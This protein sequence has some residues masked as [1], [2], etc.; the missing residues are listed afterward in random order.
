MG[1]EDIHVLE[2]IHH[3]GSGAY[4]TILC[5][6]CAGALFKNLH[7]NGRLTMEI[8]CHTCETKLNDSFAVFASHDHM[9]GRPPYTPK[10]LQDFVT[11][12]WDRHLGER[13]SPETFAHNYKHAAKELGWDWTPEYEKDSLLCPE[14]GSRSHY[15]EIDADESLCPDCGHE[16]AH[17]ITL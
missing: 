17:E 14:C 9:S 5:P 11:S 10:E 12:Y 2:E 1:D 7:W 6:V 15:D 4:G 3:S 16:F 8:D 13:F